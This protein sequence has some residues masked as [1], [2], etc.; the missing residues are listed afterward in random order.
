MNDGLHDP[1]VTV[2]LLEVRGA[3]WRELG[4]LAFALAVATWILVVLT[5]GGVLFTRPL[6]TDELHTVLLAGRATPIAVVADLANGAD[7]GPPLLHLTTWLLRIVSGTLTNTILRAA[8]MLCV[9]GALLFVYAALR[10]CFD[11]SPSVA[12]TVAIAS[13]SLVVAHSFE[14]RFYGPWLLCAAFFAWSLSLPN[15]R[16][17]DVGVAVASVLVATVHWYGVVSL[18]IMTAAAIVVHGARWREGVR[19]VRLAAIG[20]LAFTAC[21]PLAVGQRHALTVNTWVPEFRMS[22]LESLARIYWTALI[23]MLAVAVFMVFTLANVRRRRDDIVA[24]AATPLQDPSSAA[25]VSLALMPLAL[26]AMSVLGQPSMWP[27]YAIPAVLAWAPI[28]ALVAALAG[29]WPAR[30][31]TA[32]AVAVWF[33]NFSREAQYKRTF[34]IGVARQLAAVD[35]ARALGVPI[36]FQSMHPM[37]AA[38]SGDWAKR[39]STSFLEL[40]DSTIDAVLPRGGRFEALN[41]A[42]RVERDVARVHARR[43]GFPR[44]S[45]QRSLDSLPR[46]VLVASDDNLPPGYSGVEGIVV[47]VFPHHRMARLAPGLLLLDRTG[48]SR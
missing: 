16:K 9:W 42:M 31:F 29:K 11:R 35:Q 37:Y 39:S 45:A 5:D 40:P 8:S 44:I 43:F 21:V 26:A 23:P 47:A 13:H 33:V 27:R 34:A 30:A 7:Y 19:T 6:W 20:L 32:V 2:N 38:A 28:V 25:L 36:V 41:K 14:A 22:Q 17:R 48:R 3:S 15:A 10:R 1:A 46:F 4:F 24:V 12:G 18:A